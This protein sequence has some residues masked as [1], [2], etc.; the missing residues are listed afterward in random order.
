MFINLVFYLFVY[1]RNK[2]FSTLYRVHAQQGICDGF[3]LLCFCHDSNPLQHFPAKMILIRFQ[4]KMSNR[5]E[6]LIQTP[7]I[8]NTVEPLE[9]YDKTFRRRFGH[10]PFE[11][12]TELVPSLHV[13][14]YRVLIF[15]VRAALEKLGTL[16]IAR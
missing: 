4:S 5:A 7:A 2:Y 8:L 14:V 12:I 9:S 1:L 10:D 6:Y 11:P 15:T 13:F 3:Y 16:D